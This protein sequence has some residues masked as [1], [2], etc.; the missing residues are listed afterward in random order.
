MRESKS[1]SEQHVRAWPGLTFVGIGLAVLVWVIDSVLS[2]LLSGKPGVALQ[3]VS[4]DRAHLWPRLLAAGTLVVLGVWADVALA[5]REHRLQLLQRSQQHYQ[6]LFED[7]PAALVAWDCQYR[8]CNWNEAD[9]RLFGWSRE[10]ALGQNFLDLLCSGD[11]RLRLEAASSALLGGDACS[12]GMS[13]N[14]TRKGGEGILC[15][16]HSK[17]L[18]DD[19]GQ[20]VGAVSLVVD[21]TRRRQDEIRLTQHRQRLEVRVKRQNEELDAVREKLIRRERLAVLGQII[22]T[23]SHE[24]RN[25]LATIRNSF[26][27]IAQRVRGKG[28]GVDEAVDR[29]QRSITRCDKIIQDLLD[30]VRVPKLALGPTQIDEWLSKLLDE[31][32]LP[33]SIE[34]VRKLASGS[35]VL[36]DR[37]LLRRCVTNVIKNALE[38]MTGEGSPAPRSA[39]QGSEGHRLTVET[40]VSGDNVQIRITDTGP[41]MSLEEA[42]KF[43]EPLVSTKSFG[44]GLGLSMAKQIMERHRGGVKVESEPGKGATVILWLPKQ[45]RGTSSAKAENT[46]RRR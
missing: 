21:V 30:Y 39:R 36:A 13:V 10:E 16:W 41:G 44:I 29:A 26:F 27:S 23:V 14:V 31:Q 15:E 42:E 43:F 34:L 7:C 46:D 2:A 12:E 37:E 38:A 35:T 19:K 32:Q 22:G 25:P 11:E 4:P 6:S 9:E 17:A 1:D 3:V 33:K 28:L 24:L 18:R 45:R 40:R 20:I 8:V 5:R